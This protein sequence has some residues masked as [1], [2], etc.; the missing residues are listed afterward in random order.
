M[1]PNSRV[2]ESISCKSIDV[3]YLSNAM[4][5]FSIELSELTSRVKVERV[6]RN[7]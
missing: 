1:A 3:L 6:S 4:L 5:D 7:M 2:W